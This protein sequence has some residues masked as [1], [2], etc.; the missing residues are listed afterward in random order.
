MAEVGAVA[1]VEAVVEVEDMPDGAMKIVV[2][3]CEGVLAGGTGHQL[4]PTPVWG[5]IAPCGT[6]P[7]G[8]TTPQGLE[9][10]V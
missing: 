2:E 4:S 8:T 3:E 7:V 5:T 6:V 10:I 1:A 9:T